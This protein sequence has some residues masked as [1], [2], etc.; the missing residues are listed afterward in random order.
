MGLKR[1]V[2]RSL[3]KVLAHANL[4]LRPTDIALSSRVISPAVLDRIFNDLSTAI[5]DWIK[6]QV[7][8][9]VNNTIS[10]DD[11]EFFYNNYLESSY[12]EQRGGS[13]LN[14]L[15]W[16]FAL[17]RASEPSLIIDSGTYKGGSAWA[18]HLGSPTSPIL[19]FDIDLSQLV[20]R[21][22]QV[23]YIQGDWSRHD[24]SH[25]DLSTALA[26][27]DDHTDQ[28]ARLIESSER[29][30][31]LALFDDDF[32]VHYFATLAHGGMALPKVEF[33]TDPALR[34]IDTLEWIENGKTYSWKVDKDYLDRA[35]TV[36]E[37]ADRLPELPMIS[38]LHQLPYRIVRLITKQERTLRA[39]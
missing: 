35:M 15:M 30:I 3:N 29:D 11:I 9:Q 36:I 22:S 7:F 38:G 14:N 6:S 28:A 18:L 13:G 5:N 32:S 10:S 2:Y 23:E 34:A 8:F 20:R 19:S 37:R 25:Y 1:V 17:S 33:V 27:F 31:P 26:Y 12:R 21:E 39:L 4:T 24:F 16:L